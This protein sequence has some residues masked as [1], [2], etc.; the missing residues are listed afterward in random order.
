MDVPPLRIL[1]LPEEL[2][3]MLVGE[4]VIILVW[5][6]YGLL[7]S[8]VRRFRPEASLFGESELTS[9]NLSDILIFGL[10]NSIVAA[11]YASSVY[12][13]ILSFFILQIAFQPYSATLVWLSLLVAL[14]GAV[15]LYAGYRRSREIA[16]IEKT[17]IE[18]RRR[19]L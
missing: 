12:S 7:R 15:L 6:S 9:V 4:V 1:G 11:Q 14:V 10:A 16:R 17:R 2:S 18:L 5:V 19:G 8:K 3:W 13:L